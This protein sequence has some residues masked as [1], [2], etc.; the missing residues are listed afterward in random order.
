MLEELRLVLKRE[1]KAGNQGPTS[2][3]RTVKDRNAPAKN[4]MKTDRCW[5]RR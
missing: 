3:Q 1:G 5:R 4:E 2:G